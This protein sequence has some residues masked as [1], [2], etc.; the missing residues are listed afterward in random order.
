[1]KNS[2]S[3]ARVVQWGK[4]LPYTATVAFDGGPWARMEARQGDQIVYGQYVKGTSGVFTVGPTPAADE[5]VSASATVSIGYW[6]RR[7]TFRAM[8]S[9]EVAVQP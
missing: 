2:I 6:T 1:M 5:T 8:A 7:G 4:T 3:T 9:Q